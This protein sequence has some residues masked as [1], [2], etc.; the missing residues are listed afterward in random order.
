MKRAE[1]IQKIKD[2]DE[3][4]I[5]G[6]GRVAK[7]LVKMIKSQ[8]LI[9]H[10]SCIAVTDVAANPTDLLGVEIKAIWDLNNYA[11]N[12]L[13]IIA[14]FEEFQESIQKTLNSLGFEKYLTIDN[15][16]INDIFQY[17]KEVPIK[18]NKYKKIVCYAYR[19]CM[20]GISGG[21]GVALY[22]QEKY[23]GEELEGIPV[24]YRYK[25]NTKLFQKMKGEYFGA[26]LQI[27][28][29]Q[30]FEK[31]TLYITNDL[32]TAYGLA[33]LKKTYLFIF[34]H[35][36]PIVK[37]DLDFGKTLSK[38]R[39]KTLHN[40]ERTAFKNAKKIFFPS[41]GAQEMYFKSKYRSIDVAEVNIGGALYNTISEIQLKTRLE[42]EPEKITFLSLGTISMAKGQDQS[43]CFIEK[44]LEKS[45]KEIRYIVIGR[46]PLLD[47]VNTHAI[48]LK[49][50]YKNFE[51]IYI[52]RIESYEEIMRIHSIADI[53]IMLHRISIFDLSTLEAMSKKTALILSDVGGNKEFNRR[54]NVILVKE[55]DYETAVEQLINSD[56]GELK[57]KNRDV[58]DEF[59]SPTNF[60]NQYINAITQVMKWNKY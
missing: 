6:A 41:I 14:A 19:D 35:Q 55:N 18:N 37:E 49:E 36:G 15:K 17:K 45:E 53:Y 52:P 20:A 54:D 24:E 42:C 16:L 8:N 30:T 34:H 46:G 51:Y 7:A 31:H 22:L 25:P 47:E 50:E 12:S 40:I 2:N 4:I 10:V 58:Y 5:Y 23:L 21:P 39:I 44:L 29:E 38:K 33:V 59:F 27:L 43:I 57:R 3:I 9:S 32:G 1:L 26:F 48:R 13:V 56:I 11:D 28:K 60:R